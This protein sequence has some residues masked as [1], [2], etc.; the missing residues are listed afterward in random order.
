M[1]FESY[2]ID[3]KQY[4]AH[5]KSTTYLLRFLKYRR[6]EN[7]NMGFKGHT[8]KSFVSILHSNHVKGLQLKTKD[9]DHDHDNWLHFEP[10]P[11]SFILIV[12]DVCMVIT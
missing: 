6:T 10:S 11:S 3:E 7:T 5:V 2:G 8:D 4:E 1:L 12:G 9:G